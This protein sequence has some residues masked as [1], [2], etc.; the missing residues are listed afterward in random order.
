MSRLRLAV[1]VF[2][3]LAV[4][5]CAT[6]PPPQNAALNVFPGPPPQ[7][8]YQPVAAPDPILRMDLPPGQQGVASASDPSQILAPASGGPY[9][10]SLAPPRPNYQAQPAP[11]YQAQ[12]QPTYQPSP[13]ASYQ[14]IYKPTVPNTGL[15]AENGSCY[16]DLS[17]LTGRPKTV[18]V[19][20]Y[21]RKNGTYVRG[22]YR[23][24]R[25]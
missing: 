11:T 16:G 15:C 4:A 9:S 14:P 18:A 24:K 25:R 20:G 12:T 10:P 1:L 5:S 21:F 17:V 6:S 23:S 19:G 3:V 7:P 8:T 22:H 2:C 13:Q